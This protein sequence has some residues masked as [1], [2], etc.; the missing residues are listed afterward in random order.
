M[1]HSP[2]QED[3]VHR[4]EEVDEEGVVLGGGEVE[5]LHER[6]LRHGGQQEEGVDDRHHRQNLSWG[7]IQ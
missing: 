2:G 1:S 6:E 3:V 7:Q 5:G 4:V